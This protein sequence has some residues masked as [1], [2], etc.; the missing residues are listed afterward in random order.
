MI[1]NYE[2]T[3]RPLVEEHYHIRM[4]F[5]SQEKRAADRTSHRD[6]EKAREE[7]ESDIKA[8]KGKELKAFWCDTCKTDFLAEALKEVEVD[9]S[10]PAQNIAFYRTKCFKGHWCQR[11]ITDTHKDNYFFRSKKVCQDRGK[12]SA[13]IV[14]PWETNYQLLYGRKNKS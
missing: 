12:Y 7:R 4:L 8:A 2:N 5:E 10:N 9:W 11:L 1:R 3:P 6:R 14:Q 13:D